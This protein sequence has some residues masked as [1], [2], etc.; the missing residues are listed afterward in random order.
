M[1]WV[2]LLGSAVG[3]ILG[4][5]LCDKVIAWHRRKSGTNSRS[6]FT[7]SRTNDGDF[8]LIDNSDI[9]S[10][11]PAIVS[12]VVTKRMVTYMRAMD[13]G[14][15]NTCTSQ[16][17]QAL[18]FLICSIGTICALPFVCLALLL[19][20]SY[21]FIIQTLVVISNENIIPSQFRTSSVA[22]FMLIVI[23]IGGN[24]PLCVPLLKTMVGFN[25]D[26]TIH[27]EAAFIYHNNSSN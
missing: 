8:E 22:L 27:F 26:V 24:I 21:C 5:L 2:P 15:L 17:H 14:T 7:I 4:G 3:N 19:D 13:S 20:Y 11:K 10:I 12:E 25:A 16:K 6:S 23:L 1:F 9:N 18:C